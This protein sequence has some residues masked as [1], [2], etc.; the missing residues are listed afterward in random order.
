MN[1]SIVEKIDAILPQT[2][3]KKCGFNGCKPYAQ[4]I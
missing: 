4:A 3:C 2:Q 1:N